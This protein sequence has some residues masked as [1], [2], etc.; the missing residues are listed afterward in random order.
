MNY[1]TASALLT[2]RCE[3]SRKLANNT[4]LE[5]GATSLMVRLHSTHIV[6]F[7]EDG[8]TRYDTG[9]WKTHTTK[10]RMNAFGHDDIRLNADRGI[11]YVRKS[12]AGWQADPLGVYADGMVYRDGKLEGAAEDPKAEQKLRKQVAAYAKRFLDALEAGKVEAP[13]AGDCWYCSMRI[14][15]ATSPRVH[16]GYTQET[17]TRPTLGE[18]TPTLHPDGTLTTERNTEHLL[19]HMSADECYYVPSLLQRAL[20][21]MGSSKSM[22]WWVGSWWD[23]SATDEQRAGVRRFGERSRVEKAL[24]KYLFLQLGL[25]R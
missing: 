2:G 1:A 17:D 19:S 4:Y 23:P 16:H 13:S 25:S 9:G 8:S 10:D 24:R 18:G 7:F 6:E 11:W 20:E 5:R 3:R 12:S 22:W 21:V 15:N 14:E